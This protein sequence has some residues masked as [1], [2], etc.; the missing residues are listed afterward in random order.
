[1][2]FFNFSYLSETCFAITRAA[3]AQNAELGQT[4]KSPLLSLF[5]D[6]ALATGSE[7]KRYLP[8]ALK[9]LAEASTVDA[10]VRVLVALR[11]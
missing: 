4:V 1:M 10:D 11:G 5:G 6:L 3:C 9:L 7:F 8:H 2:R